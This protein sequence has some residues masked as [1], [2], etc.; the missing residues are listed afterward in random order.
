MLFAAHADAQLWR[1]PS[2]PLGLRKGVWGVL[3]DDDRRAVVAVNRA[4]DSVARA[5]LIESL[6]VLPRGALRSAVEQVRTTYLVGIHA[7]SGESVR[8]RAAGGP[9]AAAATLGGAAHAALTRCATASC[10]KSQAPG[11]SEWE[12][13][14]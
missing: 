11:P 9:W 10:R 5:A 7:K 1:V 13:V 4:L 14:I 8:A 6:N 12:I 3:D 2:R